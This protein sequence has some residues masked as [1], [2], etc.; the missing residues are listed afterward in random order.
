[1]HSPGGNNVQQHKQGQT[2]I[3]P[4]TASLSLCGRS[5]TDLKRLKSFTRRCSMA[6]GITQKMKV[7]K[8]KRY[9]LDVLACFKTLLLR[10][11]RTILPDM[12]D[13]FM[14][15]LLGSGLAQVSGAS[16]SSPG[17]ER[18]PC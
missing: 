12:L 9:L 13:F 18:T 15:T 14:L 10:A 1:M 11:Q 7:V 5:E 16:D 4:C 3:D 8:Q 2:P 6:S 17:L